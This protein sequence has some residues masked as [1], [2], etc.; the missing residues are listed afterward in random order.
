MAKKVYA[1]FL[2]KDDKKGVTSTWDECKSVI[3]G[4]KARYKS[5]PSMDEA[6]IWLEAGAQYENK[7]EKKEQMKKEL[8]DGIYFDA[9]TG[10]GIGVEVRVTDRA[11]TSLLPDLLPH[12]DVTEHGNY[13]APAGSTNNHGEL[14]GISFAL[15]LALVKKVFH[16]FGDSK[17]VI[18]YWSKGF[19]NRD[20][21]KP[22]TV[23]LMDRVAHQRRYFESLGGKVEHV[24]GDINPADLGFHR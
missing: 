20:S 7:K 17:L 6:I 10:R 21:L 15:E 14:L 24:S 4:K 2:E 22:E 18:D 11:G 16:I 5:F 23:L 8:L 19:G 12:M 1:Y 13:L 9:G 3:A